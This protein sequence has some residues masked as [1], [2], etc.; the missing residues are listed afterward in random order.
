MD[1]TLEISETCYSE[2]TVES[3]LLQAY[4]DVIN[5]DPINFLKAEIA[6][7]EDLLIFYNKELEKSK[8]IEEIKEFQENIEVCQNKIAEIEKIMR[9][10][11]EVTIRIENLETNMF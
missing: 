4:L 11:E 7:Y 3:S 5:N 9:N 2:D 10:K 1:N 6:D 8:V